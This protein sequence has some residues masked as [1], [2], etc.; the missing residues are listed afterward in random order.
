M[1]QEG[2]ADEKFSLLLDFLLLY[3]SQDPLVIRPIQHSKVA[4]SQTRDRCVSLPFL[5][6]KKR[7][8]SEAISILVPHNLDKPL[9]ALVLQQLLHLDLV[10]LVQVHVL[11]QVKLEL[12]PGFAEGLHWH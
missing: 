5:L 10:L 3:S 7:D 6:V 11:V 12:E 8:F 9:H 1:T 4:L 2:E